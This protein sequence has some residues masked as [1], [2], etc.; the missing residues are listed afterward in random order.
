M[1]WYG[2]H[3]PTGQRSFERTHWNHRMY[4]GLH[5]IRHCFSGTN[6]TVV[7]VKEPMQMVFIC[8]VK[9]LAPN[10][11][12]FEGSQFE[13]WEF[14]PMH[15]TVTFAPVLGGVPRDD[16][17]GGFSRQTGSSCS[18]RKWLL[19]RNQNLWRRCKWEPT[20]S[21]W[22]HRNQPDPNHHSQAAHCLY[23]SY[24]WHPEP[25]CQNKTSKFC[26]PKL[27]ME[28]RTL[29]SPGHTKRVRVRGNAFGLRW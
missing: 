3:D 13:S 5:T 26:R 11:V 17:V 27:Q 23:H 14:V 21:H 7:C 12:G 15:S 24:H 10:C 20:T 22:S 25:E 6:G 29:L 8:E 9:N 1:R 28:V 18:Q 4:S 19:C 2:L 16:M